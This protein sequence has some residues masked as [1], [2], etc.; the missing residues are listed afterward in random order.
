[1]R[2]HRLR[3]IANCVL[4]AAFLGCGGTA[5]HSSSTTS[6]TMTMQ[7]QPAPNRYVATGFQ[8]DPARGIVLAIAP[9]AMSGDLAGRIDVG[10]DRSFGDTAGFQLRA[11]SAQLR[12]RMNSDRQLVL[13]MN[14]IFKLE[15]DWKPGTNAPGLDSILAT[16]ELARFREVLMESDVLLVPSPFE[17]QPDGKTTSGS[18][19]AR[20]YDLRT[21]RLLLRDTFRHSMPSGATAEVGIAMELVLTA[22]A[23][24]SRDLAPNAR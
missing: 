22:N 10:F 16:H 13:L 5:T 24:I 21:G 23:S 15:D 9:V 19:T 12:G 1:M 14:R 17:F 2:V 3:V 6:S 7:A 4:C 8:P 11:S 20:A 18:F